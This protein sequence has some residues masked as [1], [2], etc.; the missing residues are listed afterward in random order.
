MFKIRGTSLALLA[1]ICSLTL[2]GQMPQPA[3]G[4]SERLN[5]YSGQNLEYD[6]VDDAFSNSQVTGTLNWWLSLRNNERSPLQGASVQV[7]SQLTTDYFSYMGPQP[8]STTPKGN[9]ILYTWNVGTLPSAQQMGI[10]L[11]SK[12]SSAFTP[13][14]D[15]RRELS[16]PILESEVTNQTVLVSVTPRESLNRIY[17]DVQLDQNSIVAATILTSSMDPKTDTWLY[18]EQNGLSWTVVHP[19]L[20]KDYRFS[21][22]LLLRNPLYPEKLLYKPRVVVS[23]LAKAPEEIE[24][25]GQSLAGTDDTLGT[26]TYSAAKTHDWSYSHEVTEQV[27]HKSV[28]GAPMISLTIDQ[29]QA[30][31]VAKGILG[32]AASAA[33]SVGTI[34]GM[35]YSIDGGEW[36]PIELGNETEKAV[37]ANTMVVRVGTVGWDTTKVSN[38]PH[39]IVIRVQDSIGLVEN[40]TVTVLVDNSGPRFLGYTQI[41]N[42]AI[43]LAIVAGI[44]GVIWMT[45]AR[46]RRPL[47]TPH[48]AAST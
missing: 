30:L 3:L 25:K 40:K 43:V 47:R 13:G 27:L 4:Q 14:F 24:R 32:I 45:G 8:N 48:E 34:V 5:I 22:T 16:P 28:T 33:S 39:E 11:E 36:L 10:S 15:S 2:L 42:F 20:N 41:I 21:V 38:G 44:V 37:Y 7:L 35:E 19:Q 17:V 23:A 6:T 29:P 26:I 1:L 9:E 12:N 18:P 31:T 46:T